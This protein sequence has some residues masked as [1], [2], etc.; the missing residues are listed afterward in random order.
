M[1]GN[2]AIGVLPSIIFF[3]ALVE[4]ANHLGLLPLVMRLFASVFGGFCRCTP[5]EAVS[6][7]ANVFVG[8]TNAPLLIKPF[9]KVATASHLVA[10]MAAGFGT[11]GAAMLPVYIS[12]G[13]PAVHLLAAAWMGAP[14]ALT[15]AKILE[16]DEK[17]VVIDMAEYSIE[18]VRPTRMKNLLAA[19]SRGVEDG[20]NISIGVASTLIA[21]I[22]LMAMCNGLVGSV[23]L[24]IGFESALT[25]DRLFGYAFTPL[26]ILLGVDSADFVTCGLLLG[27]KTLLNEFVAFQSLNRIQAG[28]DPDFQP[29]DPRSLNVCHHSGPAF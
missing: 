26:A 19:M 28:Y 22:G 25:L 14:A 20:T 9:V 15:C 18:K 8:M 10:I 23:T 12:F 11:A 3:S 6:A 24:A 29:L 17:G 16:P 27:Q 5:P 13:A 4:V 7:A 21:I 2:F 1:N